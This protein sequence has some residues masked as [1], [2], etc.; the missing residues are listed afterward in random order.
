MQN[1]KVIILTVD[2]V[3][4]TWVINSVNHIAVYFIFW[5]FLAI[6]FSSPLWSG[7]NN[8]SK[9]E[10]ITYAEWPFFHFMNAC[11]QEV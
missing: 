7:E 4:I 11:A 2:L 10:E 8:N 9:L 6:C 5:A 1:C 3:I